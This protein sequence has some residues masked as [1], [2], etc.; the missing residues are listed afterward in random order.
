MGINPANVRVSMPNLA[1]STYGQD[2]R[3][4][5]VIYRLSA[6]RY[7]FSD[8]NWLTA[9]G[10]GH[11]ASQPELQRRGIFATD[12]KDTKAIPEADE[13]ADSPCDPNA[14]CTNIPVSFICKCRNSYRGDGMKDGSGCTKLPPSTIINV[15]IGNISSLTNMIYECVY[16]SS[17]RVIKS[18]RI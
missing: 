18:V 7:T 8:Q 9:I 13:C 11:G 6:T 2:G 10:C 12:P 5:T 1:L 3:I 15:A 17:G 16:W 14:E 4:L